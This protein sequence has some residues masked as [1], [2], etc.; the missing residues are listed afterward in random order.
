MA[1][2]HT[3]TVMATHDDNGMTEYLHNVLRDGGIHTFPE[4]E[5]VCSCGVT[6]RSNIEEVTCPNPECDSNDWSVKLER[7]HRFD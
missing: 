6:I 4:Y 2:P 1:S 5:G 3:M 7:K